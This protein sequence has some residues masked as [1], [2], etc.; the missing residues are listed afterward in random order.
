[1]YESIPPSP[2]ALVMSGHANDFVVQ[3]WRVSAIKF[4]NYQCDQCEKTG[5]ED[6]MGESS[7]GI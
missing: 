7:K 5:W 6:A 3:D 2:L 4:S 1:M